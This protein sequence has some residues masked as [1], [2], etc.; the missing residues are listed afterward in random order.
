MGDTDGIEDIDKNTTTRVSRFSVA[1]WN[2]SSQWFLIPQGTG[3][4][5]VVLRNIKYRFTGLDIISEIIWIYNIA[6]LSLLVLAYML[7]VFLYP[8][9]V[10]NILRTS[11]VET[12]CL[13]SISIAFSTI[14]KM[15]TVCL[16]PK[17]GRSWGVVAFVLWS[18]NTGLALTCCFFI[19]YIHV[20]LQPPGIKSLTPTVLLPFIAALTSAAAGGVICV[21]GAISARIQVPIIIVSYLEV[22]TAVPLAM[23]MVD[24][25][26][27]RLF[28]KAFP[29]IDHVYEDMILCGPFGQGSF[30]LLILGQAAKGGAFAEYHRGTFLTADIAPGLS[31]AS[32]LAGLLAWGYATFWWSFAA[33]GIIHTFFTQPGGMRRSKFYMSAW[34]LVFPMGVY[35]NAAIFLSKIMN[36]SA[37][38]V[39]SVILAIMLVIIW[40][41]NYAFTIKGVISG[42]LGLGGDPSKE[43]ARHRSRNPA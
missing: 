3:I 29:G 12:S 4:V 37:F 10:V 20:K 33:L 9:H 41:V 11:I 1:L 16:V 2:L 5:A 25:F 6:L 17:W 30:A 42:R 14:L 8:R 15:V 13:S 18:V 35:T 21:Y 40:L 26:Q 24:V 36:S 27:S 28:N 39:W 31:A 19:P 34:S 32:Q 38:G 43:I 23:S 7:R 22:G